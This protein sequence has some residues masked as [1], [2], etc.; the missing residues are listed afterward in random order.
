MTGSLRALLANIQPEERAGLFSLIYAISYLAAAILSFI[1]GRLSH[2]MNIFHISLF[3]GALATLACF[4]TL[5]F[6]RNPS[7]LSVG[8]ER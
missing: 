7:M 8:G 1:A 6:A 4:I 5:A 3:Y 2:H